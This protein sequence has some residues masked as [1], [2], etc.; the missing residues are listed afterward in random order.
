MDHHDAFFWFVGWRAFSFSLSFLFPS[1]LWLVALIECSLTLP[2]W[3]NKTPI[4]LHHEID[5]QSS[6]SLHTFIGGGLCP[7]PLCHSE[8]T[9]L[10]LCHDGNDDDNDNDYGAC[11]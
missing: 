4:D 6:P 7:F 5:A 10:V 2:P 9:V 11:E 1:L 8:P 3:T